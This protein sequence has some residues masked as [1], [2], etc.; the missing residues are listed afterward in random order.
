M[1]LEHKYGEF[2]TGQTL[3][4]QAQIWMINTEQGWQLTEPARP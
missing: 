1:A 4:R 3:T 2:E